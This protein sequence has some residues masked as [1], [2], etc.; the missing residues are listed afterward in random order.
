VKEGGTEGSQGARD[1]GRGLLGDMINNTVE[2]QGYPKCLGH[3][4]GALVWRCV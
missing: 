1:G 3:S 4:F 2:L